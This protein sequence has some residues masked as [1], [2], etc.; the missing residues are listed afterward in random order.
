M[1]DKTSVAWVVGVT[2]EA[3]PTVTGCCIGHL[4]VGA[5]GW[6]Q[7]SVRAY[8]WNAVNASN[9]THAAL[10]AAVVEVLYLRIRVD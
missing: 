4:F 10:F 1:A 2:S 9:D 6:T 8:D 7:S 3:D 5:C